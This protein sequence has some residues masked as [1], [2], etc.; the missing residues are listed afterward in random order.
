MSDLPR[1]I[2][3]DP[4]GPNGAGLSPLNLDSVDFQSAVPQQHLHIFYEEPA[5]GLTVGVW[6][7]ATMQEAFG[8]YPGDEVIIVLDGDFAMLDADDNAVRAGRGECVAFRNAVPMSWK[9]EGYL[10]KFFVTLFTP[11]VVTPPLAT[12]EG[13]VIVVNPDSP[14]NQTSATGEP[15]EREHVA[16]TNDAGNMSVGIWDC[17][18]A[19]FEWNHFQFMSLCTYWKV[20]QRSQKGTGPHIMLRPEIAFLSPK[21]PSVSGKSRPTSKNTTRKSTRDKE[22]PMTDH[23]AIAA[24]LDQSG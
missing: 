11:D 5:I 22:L 15:V 20:L 6:D 3:L 12:A 14:L 16:F 23:K 4:N 1:L 2:H 13:A 8:P 7:T 24:G 9:Q 17:Q 10:K 18:T 19:E 21:G